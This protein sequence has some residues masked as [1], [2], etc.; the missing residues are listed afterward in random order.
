MG[1]FALSA[2][3]VAG[4]GFYLFSQSFPNFKPGNNK[5]QQDLKSMR[6]EVLKNIPDLIPLRIEDIEQLSNREMDKSLKKG[7]IVNRRGIFISIFDEPAIAFYRRVYLSNAKDVLIYAKSA[8][9]EFNFWIRGNE[10][11]LVV[12][13]QP[14]GLYNDVTGELIGSRSQKRIA[15]LDKSQEKKVLV[16]QDRIVGTFAKYLPGVKDT[17]SQR[18]FE[19]VKNDVTPEEEAILLAIG[20]YE[21]IERS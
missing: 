16:I 14:L 17:L 20:I 4:A 9:H 18:V 7:F 15:K 5:I 12:D 8:K 10:A 19:F 3:I 6:E 21:M 2:L 1:I 11:Q 13:N